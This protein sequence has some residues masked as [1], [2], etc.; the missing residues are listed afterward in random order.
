MAGEVLVDQSL[1]VLTREDARQYTL[2]KRG[3]TAEGGVGISALGDG[4]DAEAARVR[5]RMQE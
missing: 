1:E 2:P 4:G 3:V 5:E